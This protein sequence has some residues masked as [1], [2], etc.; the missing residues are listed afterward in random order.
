VVSALLPVGLARKYESIGRFGTL[1][2]LGIILVGGFVGV[3]IIESMIMPPALYLFRL[4]AG[5]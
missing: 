2:V 3:G 5:A 4:F 1:I